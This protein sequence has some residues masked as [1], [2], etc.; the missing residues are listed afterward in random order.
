M[1]VMAVLTA[2]VML[3]MVTVHGGDYYGDD[4]DGPESC[5]T[6]VE[7]VA[8]SGHSC[9]TMLSRRTLFRTVI[10]RCLTTHQLKVQ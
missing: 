10:D 3:V 8:D 9:G 2:A 5:Q 6:R 4:D 7:D 1:V